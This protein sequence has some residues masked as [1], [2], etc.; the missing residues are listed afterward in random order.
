[1]V[2]FIEKIVLSKLLEGSKR[3]KPMIDSWERDLERSEYSRCEDRETKMSN[4][5]KEEQSR[6]AIKGN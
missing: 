4:T 1:M 5:D 2:D 3:V 6:M